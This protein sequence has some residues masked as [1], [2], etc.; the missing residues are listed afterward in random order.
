MK[1]KLYLILTT[2]LSVACCNFPPTFDASYRDPTINFIRER[3]LQAPP[4][5]TDYGSTVPLDSPARWDWAWR[6]RTNSPFQYMTLT[7]SGETGPVSGSTVWLLELVNLAANSVC[8]ATTG[9]QATGTDATLVCTTGSLHGDALKIKASENSY[10]KTMDALFQD[11]TTNQHSYYLSIM[12]KNSNSFRF[13]TG[14]NFNK[15]EVQNFSW[16]HDDYYTIPLIISS[17]ATGSTNFGALYTNGADVFIDDVHLIRADIDLNRWALRLILRQTDTEP[18][19]VPGMY[20]FTLYVKK[21][22]GY[23]FPS[24]SNRGDSNLYASHFVKLRI[25]QLTNNS[26][27]AEKIFTISE[28]SQGW[29][30]LI[31]RFPQGKALNFTE[32]T[33]ISLL[34]LEILPFS[35]ARPFAGAILI[36]NPELHFFINGYPD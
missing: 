18:I 36:A 21:P 34:A 15:L 22:S 1:Y 7:P 5:P 28:L 27:L 3:T 23:T 11:I 6:G 2:I 16:Q 30:K 33:S 9:W 29:N 32:G 20:E 35:T 31:V 24:E 25:V 8:T 13:Y 26:I 19:L 14:N 10:I 12:I 17:I 4:P